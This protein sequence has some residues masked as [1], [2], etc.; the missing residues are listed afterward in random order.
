MTTTTTQNTTDKTLPANWR[1]AADYDP[2]QHLMSLKG[3][4]YLNVQN[5]LLSKI[6]KELFGCW[7][8][9]GAIGKHGYGNFGLRAG[10]TLRAHRAV[11]EFYRGPIPDSRSLDHLCHN[12]WCVNPDHLEPISQRENVMRSTN[13][14]ATNA[15]K[16]A[17][18][19]GHLFTPENTSLIVDR[20][21]THRRCKRC[22]TAQQMDY[23][24]RKTGGACHAA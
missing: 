19:H 22:H 9:T 11:Y 1:I 21:G 17:C 13:F 14:C 15:A 4:D 8:W 3:K 16:T 12:T 24:R 18:K 7:R 10:K 23:Q 5:R 6:V 2:N 20:Q